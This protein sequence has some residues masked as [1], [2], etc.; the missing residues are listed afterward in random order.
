MKNSREYNQSTRQDNQTFETFIISE[1]NS[2]GYQEC[3]AFAKGKGVFSNPLLLCGPSPCGKTHLLNSIRHFI[4]KESPNTKIGF[5]SYGD[6]LSSYIEGLLKK[7]LKPFVQE[8]M[9]YDV[10][11]IDNAH[12]MA[13]MSATEESFAGL[14]YEMLQSGK[15]IAISSD[16]KS[17]CHKNFCKCLSQKNM[18][19]GTVDIES[20]DYM[21]RKQYLM[22]IV[23]DYNILSENIVEYI[24]S[25]KQIS[26]SAM[27]GIY[28]NACALLQITGEKP[29][30]EQFF[31]LIKTY[32]SEKRDSNPIEE[33]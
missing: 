33:Q 24:A 31:E 12:S 5:V 7:D 2:Q 1:T 30:E 14:F 13:G 18:S 28:Q 4:K 27:R 21:I 29:T 15:R 19:F 8:Y 6:F 32:E 3:V 25:S 10:L 22:K 23:E 17:I 16:R 20:P 11:L 9:E 26:F